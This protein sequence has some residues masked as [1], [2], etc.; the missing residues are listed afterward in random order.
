MPQAP[1]FRY[2]IQ[3][4]II[5][6]VIQ[7]AL[8]SPTLSNFSQ[9]FSHHWRH[10]TE[11]WEAPLCD[12]LKC[13]SSGQSLSSSSS[14]VQQAVH[15]QCRQRENR[16]RW[17]FGSW[18]IYFVA[19]RKELLLTF[20]SSQVSSTTSR[21]VPP[22]WSTVLGGK[23]YFFVQQQYQSLKNLF[24]IVEEQMWCRC[25][26]NVSHSANHGHAIWA[27]HFSVSMS[28]RHI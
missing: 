23:G 4:S 27:F 20:R 18:R 10:F 25:I 16:C 13:W 6:H 19:A 22:F 11:H 21:S 1:L 8:D 9:L 28:P 12:Q 14:N 3:Y 2:T 26:L 5:F 15:P 24:S 17:K 7:L